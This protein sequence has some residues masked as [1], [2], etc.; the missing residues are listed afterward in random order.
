MSDPESALQAP[1]ASSAPLASAAEAV[2]LIRQLGETMEKLLAIVEEETA[3]VRAGKLSEAAR[4]EQTKTALAR[5][6]MTDVSRLKENRPYL[7]EVAPDALADL[8][9]RHDLFAAILQINLTVL[10]TAHAVSEG[11]IRGVS[12]AVNRKAAPQTYG[13]GGRA[14]APPRGRSEPLA[15]SRVL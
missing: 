5:Q 7:A 2:T 9:G 1:S 10:A 11:I 6:Y 4:L 3:C 12:D 8:H 14:V 15:V 13:A